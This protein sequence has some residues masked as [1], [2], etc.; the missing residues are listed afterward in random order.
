MPASEARDAG[1]RHEQSLVELHILLLV[2]AELLLELDELLLCH[3]HSKQGSRLLKEL[4]LRLQSLDL[5]LLS[6]DLSLQKLILRVHHRQV[7]EAL[8]SGISV[9]LLRR[10]ASGPILRLLL[11]L[12]LQELLKVKITI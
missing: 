8:P 6:L 7:L 1:V 3:V 9:C 11:Q 5:L 12:L 2:D 10:L 4:V